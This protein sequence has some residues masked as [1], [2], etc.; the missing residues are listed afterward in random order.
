MRERSLH[1]YRV[2]HANNWRWQIGVEWRLGGRKRSLIWS[3]E[4]LGFSVSLRIG[5]DN[6]NSQQE[7]EETS[8]KYTSE[9]LYLPDGSVDE[10]NTLLNQ[11]K[12][13]EP[14]SE[15][16]FGE[17]GDSKPAYEI[18]ITDGD[19]LVN[20]DQVIE[21]FKRM[22]GGR[23]RGSTP[24]VY[25]YYFRRFVKATDFEKC[26]RRQIAGKKGKELLLQYLLDKNLVSEPSKRTQ[27]AALKTVWEEGIG[28]PYPIN[29]KRNLGE[30]PEVQKRQSPRNSEVIPWIQAIDREEEPHLKSLV[31][32][33][34][35]LGIRPSHVRLL[36][37]NHVRYG[38]D[39][40]PNAIMTTG[41]EPGNKRMTPIKA[42]LPE[43]LSNALTE[44]KK[45]IL[46]SLPDDPIL[47]YR[48]PNGE[49]EKSQT[50]TPREYS[51]QW[52]RFQTKHL[53]NRLR[54]VDLRHWVASTNR[55]AGLSL[56]A[57][58]ALQGHKFKSSNQNENYDNPQ[59]IDIIE[60]QS[61]AIPYG[62]IGV[63]CP[64]MEIT[65]G[66]PAEL[67]EALEKCLSG[68]L[69]ASEFGE[70]LTAYLLRKIEQP[71]STLVTT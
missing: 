70:I 45:V 44:L 32:M 27:N 33:I 46:N 26:S 7:V 37:W 66:L 29:A 14:E 20:A 36:R 50:M 12:Q 10:D 65:Q 42:R 56:A 39:G 9:N 53:L 58:C 62:P 43:D 19:S 35:Q 1:P 69:K 68:H 63:V 25:E 57:R 34:F 31:F 55:K 4:S 15:P 41:R 3:F 61:R 60:E 16:Q 59:D 22:A 2:R 54:P 51:I 47:P 71:V 24:K 28:I 49:Y 8:N 67:T 21:N 17:D 38:I 23:L 13:N 6:L 64:K 40:K 52:D 30:L 11:G 18:T 5:L 48:K